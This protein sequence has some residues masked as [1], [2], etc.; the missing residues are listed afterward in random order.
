[1]FMIFKVYN[2]VNSCGYE[3]FSCPMKLNL[4][5]WYNFTCKKHTNVHV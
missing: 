5:D 3:I 4:M 1:M 2:Y